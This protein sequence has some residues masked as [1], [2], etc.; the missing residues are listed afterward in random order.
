[1]EQSGDIYWVGIW[2]FEELIK[3]YFNL[4]RQFPY[5]KI[6]LSMNLSPK[7]LMNDHYP[8]LFKTH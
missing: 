2:G 6:L 4:K 7:Q 3:Q 8:R 5:K 1:M